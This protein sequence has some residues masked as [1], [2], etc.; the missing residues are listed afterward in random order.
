M[1]GRITANFGCVHRHQHVIRVFGTRGTFVYDDAGARVHWS[2]NPGSTP[3]RLDLSAQPPSKGALIP[4]FIA[5][6]V[7]GRGSAVAFQSELDVI[8]AC[9]AA[10]AAVA[11]STS[12]EIVYV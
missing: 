1:I 4:G 2:R 11:Q 6:I 12:G 8:A 10:D 7:D 9:V 3:E 5:A